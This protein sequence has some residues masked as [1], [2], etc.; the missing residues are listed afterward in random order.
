MINKKIRERTIL[1]LSCRKHLDTCPNPTTVIDNFERTTAQ[2]GCDTLRRDR[3]RLSPGEGQQ[4]D[5]NDRECNKK[6]LKFH[7]V[8]PSC[9]RSHISRL[10]WPGR[11][12]E[13]ECPSHGFRDPNAGGLLNQQRKRHATRER[14]RRR[15]IM[16]ISAGWLP[17]FICPSRGCLALVSG[18]ITRMPT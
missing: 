13:G 14:I 6:A 16:L 12:Q 8:P 18:I 4:H 1:L 10:I 5:I 3:S 9:A 15:W 17:Q 11:C 2:Y 7:N